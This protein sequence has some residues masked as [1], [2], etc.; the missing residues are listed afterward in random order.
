MQSRTRWGEVSDTYSLDDS[1]QE[2][3]GCIS[4][5]YL[6]SSVLHHVPRNP[7]SLFDAHYLFIFISVCPVTILIRA[8]IILIIISHITVQADL[9]ICLQCLNQ[10]FP[11]SQYSHVFPRRV[12]HDPGLYPTSEYCVVYSAGAGHDFTFDMEMEKFGCETFVFDSDYNHRNYPTFI[13]SR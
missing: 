9:P 4:C 7:L 1:L 11:S 10:L 13:S 8:L 12:C 6:C 5:T 3:S 2:K